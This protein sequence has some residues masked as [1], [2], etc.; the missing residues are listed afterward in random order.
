M[1]AG[2]VTGLVS[3]QA[4]LEP[5]SCLI[6]HG[7]SQ[8]FD[9]VQLEIVDDVQSGV[10]AQFGLSCHDCH[11]GNP[12]PAV[13]IDIDAAMD[14]EYEPNPYRGVPVPSEVPSFCG[15][16]HSDPTIMTRYR[17]DV[18]V[19]Q[20]REYWTSQHG[21]ALSEGDE[22][23]ATCTSCHGFHGILSVEDRGSWVHPVRIAE[24]CNSCHGDADRMAGRTLPDG[25]PL[26][27]DQYARWRQSV[28]AYALHEKSDLSAPTCNDCHGNHGA[29]PPGVDSVAFVCGQCH[30]REAGIFRDSPKHAGFE[31]HNEYLAEIGDEGCSGCHTAEEVNV[32]ATIPVFTECTVCHGNHGIVRPT[33]AMFDPL[34]AT[35]CAFCHEGPDGADA[36][37][38]EPVGSRKSYQETL[39]GLRAQAEESGLDRR[40]AFDWLVDQALGLP[41][42]TVTAD[43]AGHDT[44][45][46][47]PEFERLFS[48]F[49]IGKTYFTY[50]DPVTGEPRRAYVT[51][52]SDCHLST[53]ATGEASGKGSTGQEI[54]DRMAEVTALSARAERVFLAARR[55]GVETRDTL[56]ELEQAIDAQINLEVLVHSFSTGE[57]SAFLDHYHEGVAHA[58]QALASG[59]EGLDELAFRRRGLAI[60]LVLIVAVLLALAMKIRQLSDRDSA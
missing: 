57:G 33:M 32:A 59:H 45:P 17:P 43:Q 55:G 31:A 14:P 35:P 29:A 20:E 26:P 6:C 9:P 1:V 46:L 56:A 41:V 51:R 21:L 18:R 53:P 44:S 40:E 58:R 48:K 8:M 23:V 13:A 37:V 60:S 25:R 34:P 5:T 52:C 19:D 30:G 2:L 28:H 36:D 7:A 38:A 22:A 4:Q 24:T 27:V 49:R 47:R 11:G 39:A 42:H 12:D 10:H 15:R 54:V 3:A 16:C 50:S